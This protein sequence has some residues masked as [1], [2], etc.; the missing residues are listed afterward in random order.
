MLPIVST[1]MA[2]DAGEAA[3]RDSAESRIQHPF[4]ALNPGFSTVSDVR[5][6]LV[7]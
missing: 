4:E 6:M 3:S 2:V 5:V 1:P 7:I